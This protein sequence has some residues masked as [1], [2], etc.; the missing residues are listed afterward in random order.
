MINWDPPKWVKDAVFY[1]IFPDRFYNGDH[2]NDPLNTSV[3]GIRPTKDSFF[4]GDLKGIINKLDYLNDLGINAIYLTPIYRSP[5]NHKYNISDYFEVDP[6]L[7]SLSDFKDL[8]KKAHNLGIRIILDSVF[9]HCGVNFWAFKDVV[10]KKKLSNFKEWFYFHD[11]KFI[12]NPPSYQTFAGLWEYPKLN[13]NNTKVQEYFLKVARYWIEECDI[14]GWRLDTP[15]KLPLDFWKKFRDV[16]KTI[17][18]DT[19]I[20]GEIW[21]YPQFWLGGD[22]CDGIMNYPLREHII[23]FVD[24]NMDAEDFDY[25]NSCLLKMKCDLS[26]YQMN[27][28]SSHDVARIMTIFKGDI[29]KVIMCMT[30]LFT[31]IGAPSIYYGDEI[32]MEGGPD[33]DCRRTMEWDQK[34]W[35]TRVLNTYKSLISLRRKNPCLKSKNLTSL[36]TFNGL[37]AFLREKDDSKIICVL[38]PRDTKKGIR[39]KIEKSGKGNKNWE[40]IFSGKKYTINKNELFLEEIQSKTSLV[41]TPSK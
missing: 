35:N 28:I 38:N 30:F 16:T 24:N 39:I 5:S 10:L 20:V 19:Y 36:L 31:Y 13:M 37:Y 6:S 9:N 8:V 40:D 27:L 4:G 17:K 7:G 18:P 2:K 3:W 29:D 12:T 1:E 26:E 23:S 34:K 11:Y 32:G 14:D 41:L 21:R 22:L 15:W 25:E 33:P